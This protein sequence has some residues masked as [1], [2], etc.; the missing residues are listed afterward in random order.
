M[1]AVKLMDNKIVESRGFQL[2]VTRVHPKSS[3][4]GRVNH[5]FLLL[6]SPP[7]METDEDGWKIAS[8]KTIDNF[9]SGS[10]ELWSPQEWK[11]LS[12]SIKQS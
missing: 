5:S 9:Y 11:R 3:A 10:G 8:G 2:S 12:D 7:A 6:A 4:N 1:V